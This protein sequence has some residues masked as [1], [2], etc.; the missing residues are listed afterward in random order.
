MIDRLNEVL[1]QLEQLPT[2]T[3]EIVATY[4]E[5]LIETLERKAAVHEN[6]RQLFPPAE[7]WKDPVGA[8]KR[9]TRHFAGRT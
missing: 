7:P 6:I 9:S 4:I 3:Q 8:W 2:E 1:P 5:V